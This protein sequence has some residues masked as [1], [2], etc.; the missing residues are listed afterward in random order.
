M[1]DV[2]IYLKIEEVNLDYIS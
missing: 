1:T 2:H